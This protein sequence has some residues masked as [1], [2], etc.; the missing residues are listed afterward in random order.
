MPDLRP[1]AKE[2]EKPVPGAGTGQA[3][4]TIAAEMN[5][6]RGKP[7]PRE[8]RSQASQVASGHRPEGGNGVA[9]KDVKVPM[10]DK[11]T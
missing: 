3:R 5:K 6:P 7:R 10:K 11:L 8:A 9:R 2:I 4:D 1:R